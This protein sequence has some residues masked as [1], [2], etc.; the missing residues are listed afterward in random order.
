MKRGHRAARSRVH[1]FVAG[2]LVAMLSLLGGVAVSDAK[3]KKKTATLSVKAPSSIKNGKSVNVTA[4][5]YA[6]KYDTVDVFSPALGGSTCAKTA[7]QENSTTGGY[8]YTVTPKK[9][10]K[11]KSQFAAS[12]P[13]QHVLCVY[14]FQS[15]NP[16][17]KQL[18]KKH[19]FVVKS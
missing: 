3:S 8:S 6:G 16:T 10:Y 7:G 2:L 12:N 9:N 13:G 15:T 14:L 11:V 17:G 4:K 19:K 1:V 5:G 18:H